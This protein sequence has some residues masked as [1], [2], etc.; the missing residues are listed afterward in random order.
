MPPSCPDGNLDSPSQLSAMLAA[1]ASTSRDLVFTVL[2]KLGA[3]PITEL[4]RY[5]DALLASLDRLGVPHHLTVVPSF[6]EVADNNVCLQHLIPRGTCCGWSSAGKLENASA[7]AR[8]APRG[9][10]PHR[11]LL[12]FAQRW[13][14]LAAA[15]REGYNVMSLDSDMRITNNP[16]DMVRSAQLNAF[17]LLMSGD[18][19]FPVHSAHIDKPHP[20]YVPIECVSPRPQGGACECGVTATPGVNAGFVWARAEPGVTNLMALVSAR[21]LAF[22]S[23]DAR[24][25]HT[26]ALD[27]ELTKSG[28]F[29][30]TVFNEQ[31]Y[32]LAQLRDGDVEGPCHPL[33]HCLP[34]SKNTTGG[35][36][37][38]WNWWFQPARTHSVWVAATLPGEETPTTSQCLAVVTSGSELIA[39]TY[40]GHGSRAA[41]L[42]RSRVARMC[43]AHTYL[44]RT[45]KNT[46][47]PL[48][49]S[50]SHFQREAPVLNAGIVHMM[51]TNSDTRGSTWTAMR[52]WNAKSS[53]EIADQAQSN[54]QPQCKP[55]RGSSQ[56]IAL[57]STATKNLSLLCFP[58]E[59]HSA[60]PCCWEQLGRSGRAYSHVDNMMG[61]L[62]WH[63]GW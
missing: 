9:L 13:W 14:F 29:D 47:P 37:R 50:S 45:V 21:L 3:G 34:R 36:P 11:S 19:G 15:T 42:P 48:S 33:D 55:T 12:L 2:G 24:S 8:L 44:Y 27:S 28:T 23:G 10:T 43:G 39:Q 25:R 58:S 61:C 6:E 31:L 38:P 5:N 54:D 63:V 46:T 17:G 1:R 18:F 32:E 49:C 26:N 35:V 62:R 4:I 16:L 7:A 52:W 60:C 59:P 57:S 51:A 20:D 53:D 30:Q 56:A 41:V 22:I 40:V